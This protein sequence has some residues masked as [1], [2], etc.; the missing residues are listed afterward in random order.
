MT[1]LS[2]REFLRLGAALF[3]T[4]RSAPARGARFEERSYWLH[5]SLGASV[6]EGYWGTGFPVGPAPEPEAVRQ[7]ARLLVETYHANR[8]YLIYHHE[9]PPE[10]LAP[11]FAAW[12]E[13]VPE[14]VTLVPTLVL[15]RYDREGSPVFERE[16]LARTTAMLRDTLGAWQAGVYDVYAGRDQ[17]PA[18]AAL[19]AAFPDGLIRVGL[20]PGEPLGPPYVAAVQDTWS[21]LCWGA[22]H[23]DWRAAGRGADTLRGWVAERNGGGRPIAWDLVTVAWDYTATAHGDYPGYDDAARNLPLPAGRN[24]LAAELIRDV[25]APTEFGGFS[26]DL[27]ILHVNSQHPNRDGPT[28][29]FYECLKRGERYAGYF[30][31]P[32]NE[33]AEIYATTP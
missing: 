21:G 23:D 17:G 9:L 33:I 1:A 14:R 6:Q 5:A 24:R 15:R 27:F 4:W 20:Q 3:T 32:L 2:R 30:A 29:A 19:A 25:A 11:V 22:T 12:R 10:R 31:T 8:L 28:R 13:A 18:L 26:S 7:A 16:A